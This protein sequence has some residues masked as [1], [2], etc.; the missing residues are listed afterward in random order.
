MRKQ[1]LQF[2]M[3]VLVLVLVVFGYF[4]ARHYSAS[5]E[6]VDPSPS[7]TLIEDAAE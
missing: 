7:F 3:L 1:K 4:Y 2:Y 6:E 5:H